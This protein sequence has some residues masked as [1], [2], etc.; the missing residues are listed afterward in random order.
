MPEEILENIY[1][2]QVPLP[3]NPL[4]ELNSYLIR[5]EKRGLLIDTGFNQEECRRAL[6]DGLAQLGVDRDR[7]DVMGT[8]LHYDHIGLVNH[9]IGPDGCVFVGEKDYKWIIPAYFR[10]Y[11]DGMD[12]RFEIEGFPKAG[13]EE[14]VR[15]NPA[16]V[17]GPEL[18][19]SR[20]RTLRGGDRLIRGGH[21]LEVVEAPG[22]TPGQLC[23]W[24]EKE[25]VMFTADHI[26]FDITPNIAMWPE[27]E[28]A[29]G[30]Y[31]DSLRRFDAYDVALALPGHRE[32]GDYHG[33]IQELLDH[34][35]GRIA[36]CLS[37]VRGRPG[38]TAYEIAGHM[39]WK[40][41]AKNWQSFPLNQQWFAVCEGLSHLD[42]LR[43]R[44]K[45]ERVSVGGI[46][47]YYPL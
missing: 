24:L 15:T 3:G 29:L 43:K 1:R 45:V 47:R 5:D 26:L 21:T 4:R 27:M 10:E 23:L 12:R 34:H 22:H 9:V 8:H 11:W 32:S 25:R 33:R 44:G 14:L 31:L 28:D 42:Y 6:F 46:H 18:G 39:T 17:L 38:G 19:G 20:Y 37:V 30:S 36:E 7:L 16:R 2:I 35:K 13:L 40:I 41:K